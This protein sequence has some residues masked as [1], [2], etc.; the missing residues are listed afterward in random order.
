LELVEHTSD[1]IAPT[2]VRFLPTFEGLFE[3]RHVTKAGKTVTL[4]IADILADDYD[5]TCANSS[6]TGSASEQQHAK[7]TTTSGANN[8][9]ARVNRSKNSAVAKQRYSVAI[10]TLHFSKA[11]LELFVAQD[12]A[13][14]RLKTEVTQSA[15][16]DI[17]GMW[18][19]S[20]C[21][22]CCCFIVVVV[23]FCLFVCSCFSNSLLTRLEISFIPEQEGNVTISMQSDANTIMGPKLVVAV[24]REPF[25]RYK[26]KPPK[27]AINKAATVVEIDTNY[28]SEVWRMERMFFA[29]F[30][31]FFFSCGCF[32]LCLFLFCFVFY[33]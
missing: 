14:N 28:T 7:P 4:L 26:T 3:L 2:T 9:N 17:V 32:S 16:S 21:C 12:S 1:K 11:D 13:G 10:E 27:S 29:F 19:V 8:S 18:F 30:A 31:L 5:D 23:V 33:V 22:C 20:C 24:D 6:A 15:N 25:I